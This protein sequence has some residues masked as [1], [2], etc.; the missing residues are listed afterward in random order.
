MKCFF[1]INPNIESQLKCRLISRIV[2]DKHLS[3]SFTFLLYISKLM[4]VILLIY[5]VLK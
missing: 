3:L 4:E 5:M 1:I 2:Q